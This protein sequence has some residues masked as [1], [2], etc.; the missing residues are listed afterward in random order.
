MNE[1]GFNTMY[2]PDVM[3]ALAQYCRQWRD[4]SEE[5]SAGDL[6]WSIKIYS[7]D[8]EGPAYSPKLKNPP[9]GLVFMPLARPPCLLAN[10]NFGINLK[11]PR[12]QLLEEWSSAV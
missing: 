7:S 9:P 2:T 10:K 8:D 11:S 12:E 6:D 5:K 3:R 1:L 4:Q